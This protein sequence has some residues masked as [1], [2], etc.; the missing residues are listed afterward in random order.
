MVHSHYTRDYGTVVLAI[1]ICLFLL[2]IYIQNEQ[3]LRNP[4]IYRP[5]IDSP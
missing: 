1:I 4:P 5:W 3:S 2:M